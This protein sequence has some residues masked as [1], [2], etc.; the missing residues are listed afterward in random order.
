M[1]ENNYLSLFQRRSENVMLNTP[2]SCRTFQSWH[3]SAAAARRLE[4][5]PSPEQHPHPQAGLP[6]GLGGGG[7]RGTDGGWI[8]NGPVGAFFVRER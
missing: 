5:H 7:L 6:E 3:R 8:E 1:K 2:L 4:L